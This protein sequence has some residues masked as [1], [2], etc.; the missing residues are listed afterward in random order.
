M[1]AKNEYLKVTAGRVVVCAEIKLKE[2][3][4]FNAP[5]NITSLLS[6]G[7][8]QK[9]L[10]K[11]LESL[12]YDYDESNHYLMLFGYIWFAGFSWAERY[13][14]EDI[15]AWSIKE[16]PAIAEYLQ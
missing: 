14:D 8:Q 13:Q 6:V 11:F 10:D 5:E 3:Y 7:Y 15:Q 12:N 4:Y 16:C 1:N 2:P 9:E